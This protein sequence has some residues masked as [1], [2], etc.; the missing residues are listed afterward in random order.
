M[1]TVLFAFSVSDRVIAKQLI[2]IVLPT[3]I[4]MLMIHIV[5]FHPVVLYNV[6]HN[7][8]DSVTSYA[9]WLFML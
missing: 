4:V 9:Y 5:R 3:F 2:L 7:V 1:S 6:F 8:H